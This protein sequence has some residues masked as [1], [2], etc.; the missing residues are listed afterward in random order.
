[1]EEELGIFL[2]NPPK[3]AFTFPYADESGKVWGNAYF[4]EYDGEVKLQ[5]SEVEIRILDGSLDRQL[6]V[7][8]D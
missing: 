3:L 5:E 4:I 6:L 7:F 1:M 8:C 2:D